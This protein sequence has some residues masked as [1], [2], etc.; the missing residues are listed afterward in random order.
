MLI[1]NKIRKIRE[2]KNFTQEYVAERLNMSQSSYSR[3]ESNEIDVSVIKLQQIA[4]LF[5]IKV[6]ELI[7]F[8][9][10]Y[11]FNNVNAQTINGDLNI[12]SDRERV[13]YEQQIQ[14]LKNEVDYLKKILN[15]ALIK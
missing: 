8:D 1:G 6:N 5:E 7:D 13:L 9:S 14:N 4:D 10:K 15:S 2:F 11:F 12:I 3:I